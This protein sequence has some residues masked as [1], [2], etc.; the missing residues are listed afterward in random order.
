MSETTGNWLDVRRS[1]VRCD[2][3]V[4]AGD[5]HGALSGPTMT[6][7]TRRIAMGVVAIRRVP[8]ISDRCVAGGAS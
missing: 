7:G 1:T 6:A 5:A 2:S 8:P 3:M 4:C